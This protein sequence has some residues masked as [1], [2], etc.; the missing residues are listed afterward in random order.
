MLKINISIILYFDRYLL[1][2]VHE[3]SPL[4][5]YYQEQP[6]MGRTSISVFDIEITISTESVHNE[7]EG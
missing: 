3:W 6:P 7:T 4:V 2:S 1:D 5:F